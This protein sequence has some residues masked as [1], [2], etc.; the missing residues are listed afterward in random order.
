LVGFLRDPIAK[1]KEQLQKING[2]PFSEQFTPTRAH[3][4]GD[5]SPEFL[6]KVRSASEQ[7]TK[8]EKSR[9]PRLVNTLC[10]ALLSSLLPSSAGYT[11][12]LIWQIVQ[13]LGRL[14]DRKAVPAL[15]LWRTKY[16]SVTRVQHP[17][18]EEADR[19]LLA[20]ETPQ[21]K[22][23]RRK[24][25]EAQQAPIVKLRQ[26]FER[27][28][29]EKTSKSDLQAGVI[30]TLA[31][32][33]LKWTR[34]LERIKQPSGPLFQVVDRFLKSVQ[35]EESCPE[36]VEACLQLVESFQIKI[37]MYPLINEP[38]LDMIRLLTDLASVNR[39]AILGFLASFA[40]NK[41]ANPNARSAAIIALGKIGDQTTVEP[42]VNILEKEESDVRG[43]ISDAG[44]ALIDLEDPHVLVPVLESMRCGRWLDW[45]KVNYVAEHIPT[46]LKAN[47]DQYRFVLE[48]W[49]A[50]RS[51]RTPKTE[52]R[53]GYVS[54]LERVI[55][56]Y[57][58]PEAIPIAKGWAQ[59]PSNER[60]LEGTMILAKIECEES[61]KA[62]CE[63]LERP[64]MPHVVQDKDDQEW[65]DKIDDTD[66]KLRILAIKAL[67]RRGGR[68]AVDALQHATAN[69]DPEVAKAAKEAILT[70]ES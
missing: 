53:S 63:I 15:K 34:V 38:S 31:R 62:L 66:R 45:Q 43:L 69:D 41:A 59:Y 51:A 14:N 28:I 33:G 8:L 17:A 42:L 67:A 18:K 5:Y 23:E 60:A 40:G 10:E 70:L 49:R 24:E 13:T 50:S 32:I 30:E 1:L 22:E 47:S 48:A 4:H 11:D 65:A 6:S 57:G 52:A 56:A 9:D 3:P 26:G 64:R 7:I 21:E 25:E 61:S 44:C 58:G 29:G 12:L 46:F 16:T 20:W 55:V 35:E 2:T 36:L 54:V 68:M 19:I 39:K 27:I 37:E